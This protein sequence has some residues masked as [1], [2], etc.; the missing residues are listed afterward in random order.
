M[1]WWQLIRT[2]QWANS[3]I[4]EAIIRLILESLKK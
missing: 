1:D 3:S 2:D 4:A